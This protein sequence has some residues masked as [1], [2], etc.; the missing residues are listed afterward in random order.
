MSYQDYDPLEDWVKERV[1]YIR[2][3]ILVLGFLIGLV[4]GYF[5]AYLLYG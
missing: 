1:S 4:T 5:V 3:V 2:S